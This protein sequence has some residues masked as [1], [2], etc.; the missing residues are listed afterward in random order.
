[1]LPVVPALNKE[2]V[3]LTVVSE[4]PASWLIEPPV[5]FT[6]IRLALTVGRT[7]PPAVALN[8]DGPLVVTVGNGGRRVGLTA[9][10]IAAAVNVALPLVLTAPVRVSVPVV[11]I[12]N[13]PAPTGATAASTAG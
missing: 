1:M 2:V 11:V 10:L 12:E 4:V 5:A 13:I 8:T 6:S 3:P 9:E 7:T